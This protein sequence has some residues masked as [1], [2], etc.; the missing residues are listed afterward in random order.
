MFFPQFCTS[1]VQEDFSKA[2]LCTGLNSVH[3]TLLPYLGNT[4]PELVTRSNSKEV[5]VEIC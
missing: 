1:D 5:T 2:A 3:S 4:M